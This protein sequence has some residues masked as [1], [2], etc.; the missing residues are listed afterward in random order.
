M[1]ELW[2]Y[3]ACI[4]AASMISGSKCFVAK[5][6]CEDLRNRAAMGDV[7]TVYHQ[8]GPVNFSA[9][10]W[11]HCSMIVLGNTPRRTNASTR[12]NAS[13]VPRRCVAATIVQ[14]QQHSQ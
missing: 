5:C 12:R 1:L 8:A 10:S 11:R 7:I 14:H 6:T 9:R 2:V 3:A 4:V 13:A